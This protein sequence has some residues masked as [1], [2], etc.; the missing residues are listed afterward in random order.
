[1]AERAGDPRGDAALAAVRRLR[2][3]QIIDRIDYLRG[4]R[5]LATRMTQADLAK[6]LG[7]TQ[8]SISSALKSAAKVAD[9]P[10]GFSGASVYEIAERFTAGEL[11]RKALVDQLG[12]WPAPGPGQAERPPADNQ[13]EVPP[14]LGRALRHGL[15]DESVYQAVLAQ[16]RTPGRPSRKRQIGAKSGE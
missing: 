14:D 6:A 10:E 2:H 4:L 9:P 13:P 11:D 8:P 16:R 7:V 1:M 15:L 5:R 12:R 3:R